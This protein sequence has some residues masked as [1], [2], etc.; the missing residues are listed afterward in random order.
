MNDQ[1]G[2]TT[3]QVLK[4]FDG[5]ITYRQLDY[6]VRQGY[7]T[8]SISNGGGSGTPRRW[9][10]ADVDRVR[11]RVHAARVVKSVNDGTVWDLVA[12]GRI[13]VNA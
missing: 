12:D 3:T 2:L 10:E 7:V 4:R 1:P 11:T 6:W 8:P 5:E 9:S 13:V